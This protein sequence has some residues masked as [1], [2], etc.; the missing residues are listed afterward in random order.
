MHDWEYDDQWY[1]GL[2][3]KCWCG[4]AVVLIGFFEFNASVK[5]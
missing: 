3:F 4:D 2:I 1:D 5:K